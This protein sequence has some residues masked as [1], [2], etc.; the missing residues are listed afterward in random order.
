MSSVRQALFPNV[1][2]SSLKKE[3]YSPIIDICYKL[4]IPTFIIFPVL[5]FTLGIAGIT[6]GIAGIPAD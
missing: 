4:L 6:L 5:P 3:D 2:I 1:D